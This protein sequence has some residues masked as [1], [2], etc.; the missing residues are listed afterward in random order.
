[1]PSLGA[2]MDAGTLVEWHKKPGDRV[3]RGDIVALVETQKGLIEVEI[4]QS[5]V[6]ET[7]LVNPGTEVPVGTVLAIV[8]DEP[9]TLCSWNSAKLPAPVNSNT[10]LWAE[11]WICIT[12][13][14][15]LK[16]VIRRD[17]FI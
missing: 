13:C 15:G 5:G 10:S 4:W 7:I 3:R 2:D 11:S 8:R 16:E 14:C 6:I 9:A 17:P 12:I 1:M